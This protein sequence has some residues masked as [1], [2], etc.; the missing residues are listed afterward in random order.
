MFTKPTYLIESLIWATKMLESFF[1]ALNSKSRNY[2]KRISDWHFAQQ[3]P[4]E[5][6]HFLCQLNLEMMKM[7]AYLCKMLFFIKQPLYTF[8]C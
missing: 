5:L 1:R 6:K 2:R 4:V 7:H 8:K 3:F